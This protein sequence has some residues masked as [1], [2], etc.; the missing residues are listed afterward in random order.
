[1]PWDAEGKSCPY[2]NRQ[3]PGQ[4][5]GGPGPLAESGPAGMQRVIADQYLPVLRCAVQ[6]CDVMCREAQTNPT[7]AEWYSRS[8]GPAANCP[9]ALPHAAALP[10]GPYGLPCLTPSQPPP[11]SPR[12]SL[13]P[14]PQYCHSG[15]QP[16]SPFRASRKPL[17]PLSR[18]PVHT[19]PTCCSCTR[20]GSPGSG[21]KGRMSGAT[22]RMPAGSS[23]SLSAPR[24]AICARVCV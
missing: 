20:T 9:V 21:A 3:E 14:G 13:R 19:Q 17:K 12:F 6:C 24:A 2:R 23:A 10:I 22:G 1:M 8:S 11:L 16:E 7:S 15:P 4:V 18:S 5:E